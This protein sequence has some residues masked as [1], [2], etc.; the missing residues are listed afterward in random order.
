M[1]LH[2]INSNL[3]LVFIQRFLHFLMMCVA[4]EKE[5]DALGCYSAMPY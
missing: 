2:K 1:N 3:K 5:A 4:S